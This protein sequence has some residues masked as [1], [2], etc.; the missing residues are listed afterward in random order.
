MP[1]ILYL[2]DPVFHLAKAVIKTQD[3]IICLQSILDYA[4]V[5]DVLICD[6][7]NCFKHGIYFWHRMCHKIIL[8]CYCKRVDV[9]RL[10]RPFPVYVSVSASNASCAGSGA[11]SNPFLQN[12]FDGFVTHALKNERTTA[13]GFQ[14]RITIFF[15]QTQQCL[16]Q[17]VNNQRLNLI[18]IA[19]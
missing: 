19:E 7:L 12:G 9:S 3:M 16:V 17:H 10:K 11:Y 2:H 14:A 13:S 18:A 6:N 1:L 5:N 8:R 4:E 15:L